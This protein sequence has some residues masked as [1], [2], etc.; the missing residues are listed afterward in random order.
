M[1]TLNDI[2]IYGKIVDVSTAGQIYIPVPDN[3][4]VIKIMTALNGAIATAPAVLTVKTA[5]GTVTQTLSI[6]HTS[7]AAGDVDSADL[8]DNNN[9]IEGGYIEV[10]TSGASTNTISVEVC[11]VVRR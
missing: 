10:E 6:T 2:F 7:S 1:R 8:T 5:E 9:V 4:K 3:G 11:L